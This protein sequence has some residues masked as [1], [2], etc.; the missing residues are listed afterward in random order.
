[1]E[2]SLFNAGV[3]TADPRGEEL[4]IPPLDASFCCLSLMLNLFAATIKPEEAKKLLKGSI[5]RMASSSSAGI[6]KKPKASNKVEK[7]RVPSTLTQEE[8]ISILPSRS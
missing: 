5:K 7:E 4:S 2:R 3:S 1:M 8:A 6:Q